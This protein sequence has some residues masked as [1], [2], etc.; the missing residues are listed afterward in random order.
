M[1]NNQSVKFVKNLIV[2]SIS[3]EKCYS[4]VDAKALA[5]S[6]HR[7]SCIL[8]NKFG[9]RDWVPAVFK[10]LKGANNSRQKLDKKMI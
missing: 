10:L 6:I 2:G 8:P 9:G 7:L 5:L 1:I 3:E 4:D